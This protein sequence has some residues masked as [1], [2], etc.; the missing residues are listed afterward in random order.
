MV[1]LATSQKVP[2]TDSPD[3]S[4][5]VLRRPIFTQTRLTGV[6]PRQKKPV[7]PETPSCHNLVQ[8][9]LTPPTPLDQRQLLPARVLDHV[10]SH[11]TGHHDDETSL[12]LLPVREPGL[13][14]RGGVLTPGVEH[15]AEE[16][17]AEGDYIYS[18][19]ARP[20]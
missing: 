8:L 20:G 6:T 4:S 17:Q 11:E 13:G 7:L 9:F 2:E 10:T 18:H 5:S 1:Q 19:L 16:E 14:E 12:L 15:F 3:H